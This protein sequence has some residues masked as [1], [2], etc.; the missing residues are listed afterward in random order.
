[1]EGEEGEDKSNGVS[2][3]PPSLPP[4]PPPPPLNLSEEDWVDKIFKDYG[5][6]DSSVSSMSFE[7]QDGGEEEEEKVQEET[8]GEEEAEIEETSGEEEEEI[9]ETSGEEEEE[10]KVEEQEETSSEEEE[11]S[12][13]EAA[14]EIDGDDNNKE[15]SDEE[16]SSSEEDEEALSWDLTIRRFEYL[17]CKAFDFVRDTE[18]NAHTKLRALVGELVEAPPAIVHRPLVRFVLRMYD[19]ANA[20]GLS[21]A[22]LGFLRMVF[23]TWRC[24]TSVA[25]LSRLQCLNKRLSPKDLGFFVQ[26]FQSA[27]ESPVLARLFE[28]GIE[29]GT[30]FQV[31]DVVVERNIRDVAAKVRAKEL[32]HLA[33]RLHNEHHIDYKLKGTLQ[34]SPYLADWTRTLYNAYISMHVHHYIIQDLSTMARGFEAAA[35]DVDVA[36]SVTYCTDFL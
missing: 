18:G 36:E 21:D 12:D 10:A 33:A 31:L 7:K 22:I 11:T 23:D 15:T 9:E 34:P 3:G 28:T 27:E 8:S 32:G 6:T 29:A 24:E 13:E 2:T 19:T 16:S 26:R 14:E 20:H 1:M 25:L 5:E 17:F 35:Q 4:P 30:G